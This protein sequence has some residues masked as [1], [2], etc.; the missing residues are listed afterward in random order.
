MPVNFNFSPYIFKKKGKQKKRKHIEQTLLRNVFFQ[1]GYYTLYWLKRAN[2]IV[3]LA[4][5]TIIQKLDYSGAD[6]GQDKN[7]ERCAEG[8]SF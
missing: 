5:I 2:K 3:A 6:L 4:R 7:A 1:R 8:A